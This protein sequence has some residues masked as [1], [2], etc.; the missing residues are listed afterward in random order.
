MKNK[1]EIALI[2]VVDCSHYCTA[3]DSGHAVDE[4]LEIIQ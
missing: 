1:E 4:L 2:G 3:L